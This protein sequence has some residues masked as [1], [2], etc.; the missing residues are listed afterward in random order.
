[1]IGEAVKSKKSIYWVGGGLFFFQA[2]KFSRKF[3]EGKIK[4]VKVKTIQP[5]I[6]EIKDLLTIIKKNNIRILPK[7]FVS[8]VGYLIYENVVVIGIIQ[9]K[10]VTTIQIISEDCVKAFTNYFNVMWSIANPL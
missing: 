5:D 9:E 3:I 6:P 4:E 7:D 8:R 1:M 2:L 10:E